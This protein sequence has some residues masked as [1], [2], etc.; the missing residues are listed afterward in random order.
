MRKE[1]HIKTFLL[2]FS[3]LL[4]LYFW[5]GFL[6]G[7][8]AQ[9]LANV[10]RFAHPSWLINDWFLSLDTIYRIPFN[11]FLFPLAKIFNL[12][13]LAF[14]SRILLIA[15][16]SISLTCFFTTIKLSAGSIALFTLVA[17]RMKGMIA[18]EDMLWHVEAKVLSYILVIAG[19]TS[20]LKNRHRGMWMFLGGAAAFH[21]LVG[22]YSV[23]ALLFSL[24]FYSREEKLSISKTV[25]FFTITGWPGIGIIIYNL[26]TSRGAS[27]GMADLIY[28]ARH[29]HHMI[30]THFIRHVHK[31][32][33]P[34]M[35]YTILISNIVFCI[36][37][38]VI[39]FIILKDNS[40]EK[41]LLYFTAGSA[42]IFILGLIIYYTGQYH[43]LKYYPFRFP[44]VIV[45]FTAYILFLQGADKF[46]LLKHKA[47]SVIIAVLVTGSAGLLFIYQTLNI[48]NN[49]EPIVLQEESESGKELYSWI[50]NNTPE[51]AVFVIY[52]GIDNF[53]ITADRA[54]FATFKHI[55][56]SE[57]DVM[58][59]Y[60][61]LKILNNGKDFYNGRISFNL[62]GFNN[63]YYSLTDSQL[64]EIGEKYGLDYYVGL[65]E[66]TGDLPEVYNNGKWGVYTLH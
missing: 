13:L 39:A 17:F 65:H 11:I 60:N 33:P 47:I 15:L 4:F 58:E 34:W 32:F 6:T 7:N 45:P 22:G 38:L 1:K 40:K 21:P 24:P 57:K 43:L 62:S 25:P 52:P 3:I 18:G 31:S 19:I 50:K 54:Q 59:W 2:I 23:I 49:P 14:F 26:I 27:G 63:N 64:T 44:D 10:Y 28:V 41:K 48:I 5:D 46:F 37:V 55:P 36:T 20:L 51:D 53:N 30:P 35:D 66:R 29:P 12:T 8:E 9:T 56:Q 16:M 42:V 61:R